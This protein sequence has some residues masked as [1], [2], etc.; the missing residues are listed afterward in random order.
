MAKYSK[1]LLKKAAKEARN[2]GHI[3][4]SSKKENRATMRDV[5][6]TVRQERRKS[7][8][9]KWNMDPGDLVRIHDGYLGYIVKVDVG[10][11]SK[12]NDWRQEALVMTSRGKVSVHPKTLEIIQKA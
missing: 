3:D 12:I 10:E 6:R 9:I 2:N 7:T 4:K 11:A 5:A 1:K 8:S